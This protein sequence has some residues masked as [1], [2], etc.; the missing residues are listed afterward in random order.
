[1][2]ITRVVQNTQGSYAEDI[3]MWRPN[4]PDW[5]LVD[6]VE[7]KDGHEAVYQLMAGD[8]QYPGKIRLGVYTKNGKTSVSAKFD[9]FVKITADDGEVTYEP[10]GAVIAIHG[11]E[12]QTLNATGSGYVIHNLLLFSLV[13]PLATPTLQGTPTS[14]DSTIWNRLKFG[15]PSFDPSQMD[16]PA[17]V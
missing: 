11:P 5:E 3:S 17:T 14:G 9:T 6:Q 15:I 1:M 13:P 10:Y 12:G 2:A 7:V 16:G 8:P 4:F